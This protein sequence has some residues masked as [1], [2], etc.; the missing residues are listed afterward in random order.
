VNEP[1][2]LS[3]KV[4]CPSCDREWLENVFADEHT[5]GYMRTCP[6]PDCLRLGIR[7]RMVLDGERIHRTLRENW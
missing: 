6:F 1:E 2:P 4:H 3:A 7:V 5:Q